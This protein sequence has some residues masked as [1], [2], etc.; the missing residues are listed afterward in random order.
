MLGEEFETAFPAEVI[1]GVKIPRTYNEAL[2][3]EKHSKHWKA[4]MAAEM[5]ALHV[6]HTF[7]EVV[8]PKGSN[9]VSCKWVFTIKT[10]TDGTIERYKARL[11]SRGFSQ[12]LG[13]D[14]TETFAPTVRMDTLRM[15]LA[16]VAKE[17]LE[18]YQFDIKNAFTESH[19]KEVIY[20]DPPKNLGV[21]KGLV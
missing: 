18:C 21:K 16:T 5:L 14:Y 20:L 15:F 17:D 3:D 8:L 11:V 12:V 19:L 1:A 9:L 7:R 4:A 2:A 13:E 6:N 10:H